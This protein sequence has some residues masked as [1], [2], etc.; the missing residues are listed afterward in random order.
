[1]HDDF[2]QAQCRGCRAIFHLCRLHD[3]GHAYCGE[4]CRR[5]LRTEQKREARAAHQR[6]AEGLADHR[7]RV[8][9]W[10]ARRRVMDHGSQKLASSAFD[11][12]RA[13][14]AAPMV[15]VEG[16]PLQ[17]GTYAASVSTSPRPTPPPLVFCVVCGREG[18]FIRF[19]HL[20]WRRRAHAIVGLPP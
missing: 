20:A 17:G 19:R 1:M 9:A 13:A 3:R 16:G 8:R 7:D 6:S 18:L 4:P 11:T 15:G 10:R 2:R 12:P 5:R 14:A